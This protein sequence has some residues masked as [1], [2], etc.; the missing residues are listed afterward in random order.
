M[1]DPSMGRMGIQYIFDNSHA[2]QNMQATQ[3]ALDQLRNKHRQYLDSVRAGNSALLQRIQQYRQNTVALNQQISRMDALIQ[4]HGS[5]AA[6]NKALTAAADKKTKAE[7]DQQKQDKKTEDSQA[8]LI[9]SL[10]KW[11]WE[12]ITVVFFLSRLVKALQ[13]VLKQV[14][15]SATQMAEAGGV[16]ALARMYEINLSEIVDQF[17]K[18]SEGAIDRRTAMQ[19]VLKGMLQDHGEFVDEYSNLW[20]AAVVA[21][22]VSGGEIVDHYEA[23]VQAVARGEGAVAD[24]T[25]GYFEAELALQRYANAAGVA[26]EDLDRTVRSQIVYNEVMGKTEDLV[27]EGALAYDDMRIAIDESN[28]SFTESNAL[29]GAAIGDMWTH[30]QA[31]HTIGKIYKWVAERVNELAA[32]EA[33]RR[34]QLQ[35][36]KE[37]EAAGEAY[38]PYEWGQAWIEGY[39]LYLD[40]IATMQ[41]KARDDVDEQLRGP[42]A[43]P[44][45]VKKANELN[46]EPLIDHLL[47]RQDLFDQYEYDRERAQRDFDD[48]MEDLEID[49][50]QDID[51]INRKYVLDRAREERQYQLSRIKET[52]RYYIARRQAEEKYI[53]EQAQSERKYRLESLQNERLYQYERGLLVAYGDVLAIEDLDARYALEKRARE[54]NHL[55]EQR[56]NQ[57][58][59]NLEQNQ[60]EEDYKQRLKEL[61]DAYDEQLKELRIRWQEQLSEQD[62]AFKEAT[63]KAKREYEQ[64]LEDL[65]YAH[66]Q[67][68]L[69][70]D[71]QWAELSRRTEVGAAAINEILNQYFGPTGEATQIITRFNSR[72][73]DMERAAARIRAILGRSGTSQSRPTPQH[74]P[75]GWQFGG[76]MI[77]DRPSV[78]RVSEG[79]QAERISVQ[80]MASIGHE[81]TLS[82]AGNPIAVQGS[83]LDGADLS[84]LGSA[85][86]KGVM[87][88][89]TSQ[90][91]RARR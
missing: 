15:E 23:I 66:E 42:F 64:R 82:W 56:E 45:D 89:L 52:E 90:M 36:A 38:Y 40:K 37:K 27:T 29:I 43:F 13:A 25:A 51:R 73:F 87:I 26:V 81:M 62:I 22:R 17:V 78:V 53:L 16:R 8:G 58:D 41:A 34:Y 59:Y 49:H 80:P 63:R 32:A 24:S 20:K 60:R 86:V 65:K 1:P 77:T 70:W 30:S 14:D 35:W 55:R 33:A 46:I 71:Q 4:K 69:Q 39:N 10:R 67:E 50:Q 48:R 76:S 72:L 47:K 88:E 12:I 3:R 91:R 84:G 9:A 19:A 74:L 75:E 85:I 31:L 7:K 18:V 83:G 6:A 2:I 28:V 11:R 61:K 68:L 54:E 21:T 5:L 57:E 79:Y 44:E